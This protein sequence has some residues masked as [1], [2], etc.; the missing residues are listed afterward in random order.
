VKR[1]PLERLGT[2]RRDWRRALILSEILGP[3]LARRALEAGAA[4]PV[5]FYG[6]DPPADPFGSERSPR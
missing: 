3:C 2:Q 5:R 6:E 4:R 1:S